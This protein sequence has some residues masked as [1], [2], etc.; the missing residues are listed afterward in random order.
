[1][2]LRYLDGL[3]QGKNVA[4]NKQNIFDVLN[5][6]KIDIIFVIFCILLISGYYY[7][8]N[9]QQVPSHDGAF[10]LLNARDWLTNKPLDEHYRPPLISWF[11]AGVWS[12]TGEDWVIV[13]WIQPIFTIGS[14][15][16]LYILLRKYKGRL[17][18]FGVTALTM[19]QESLFIASGYIQPEGLALFFLVLMIYLLKLQKE[20]YWFLAGITSALTFASRYPIFLQ[21]VVIF[22]VETITVKKPK[23]ALRVILGAAPILAA[24]VSAIYLK[25][26]IFQMAL[27]KDT[28]LTTSLSPFYLLNSVEIWGIA[29]L[30]VPMALLQKRTYTDNFNYT[31]IAWFVISLLFWSSNNENHQFRFTI[32]FTPAVYFLSILAI[33]N[34]VKDNHSL[35]SLISSLRRISP[36]LAGILKS[37]SRVVVIVTFTVSSIILVLFFTPFIVS[38][39]YFWQQHL[40]PLLLPQNQESE[41]QHGINKSNMR[42]LPSV[43]ITS[44]V[45]GQDIL[46]NNQDGFH[47]IGTS[48]LPL[49]P[50]R[51]LNNNTQSDCQVS[52]IVNNM[53]PYQRAIPTGPNGINDYSRWEFEV[54][55]DYTQLK[56]GE[57][58]ISAK[59]SC[60]S[61]NNGSVPLQDI[62]SDSVFITGVVGRN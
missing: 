3:K 62:K 23:L 60:H 25:A 46:A 5:I 20:K 4:R 41:K 14:G 15:I 56:E 44:P 19:T 30:L 37:R 45:Q 58:R 18:A 38:E 8:V 21:A 1:M 35:N 10:Y 12:I 6:Y 26:G 13:K 53:R 51:N 28:A 29:F 59:L 24:V 57:N 48:T 55:S 2:A 39:S 27:A 17:F 47:V 32:Q 7:Y 43:K 34:I 40:F 33:E 42:I 50:M 22:F 31:F 61:I 11:I 49:R 54:T 52:V 9:L 16:I 36:R